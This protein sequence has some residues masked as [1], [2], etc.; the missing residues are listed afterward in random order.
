MNTWLR[1]KV[2]DNQ[3]NELV[4]CLNGSS[5]ESVSSNEPHLTTIIGLLVP[6]EERGRLDSRNRGAD[7]PLSGEVIRFLDECLRD[8]RRR[9][10]ISR[11]VAYTLNTVIKI[12]IQDFLAKSHGGNLSELRS[13]IIELLRPVIID[14]V[15]RD[16]HGRNDPEGFSQQAIMNLL[17]YYLKD[18]NA[19][20]RVKTSWIA[21]VYSC[22]KHRII[23]DITR[24]Q[25]ERAHVNMMV[26]T[27]PDRFTGQ[28]P[29]GEDNL[30]LDEMT[31]IVRSA[32]QRLKPRHQLILNL[33]MDD[34]SIR[35]IAA[36]LKEPY[37]K[38]KRSLHAARK[39]LRN[40]RTLWKYCD[41]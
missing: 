8:P 16:L 36:L 26:E 4:S 5:G 33:R 29:P 20:Q 31:F 22:A 15:T 3:V 1:R 23:D 2:I 25:Q 30:E 39:A 32:V 34:H 7:P 6:D 35:D 9:S 17:A 28:S 27:A 12:K 11:W 10:S 41:T 38:V 37:E 13:E 18:V 24:I 21:V 19:L 14:V 40:D